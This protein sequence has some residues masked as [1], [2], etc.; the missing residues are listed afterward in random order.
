[1][2]KYNSIDNKWKR[3]YA[4]RKAPNFYDKIKHFKEKEP[5][6]RIKGKYD[7]KS[8]EERIA[9]LLGEGTGHD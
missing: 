8:R 3:V 5:F 9:Q 4:D 2:S 6:V 7:N 1:M